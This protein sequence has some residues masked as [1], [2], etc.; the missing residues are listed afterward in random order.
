[1]K[2]AEALR[3]IVFGDKLE[4]AVGCHDGFTAELIQE[5][6]FKCALMSGAG[7]AGSLLGTP[8]YGLLSLAEMADAAR[9]I[10]ACV[11]IPIIG[12]SFIISP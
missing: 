8:D 4:L 11:D 12:D 7:L 3:K 10:C 6:G 1:M 5:A 9:R 2:K